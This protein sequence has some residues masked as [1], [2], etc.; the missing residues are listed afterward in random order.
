MEV[1]E[2]KNGFDVNGIGPG[3]QTAEISSTLGNEK[4]CGVFI[5]CLQ[6]RKLPVQ[7]EDTPGGGIMC[8]F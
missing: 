2:N 6:N 8:I 1:M 4:H 3:K 7:K 5:N